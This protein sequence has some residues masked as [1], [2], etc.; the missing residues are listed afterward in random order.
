V[1]RK[2]L[3]AILIALFPAVA[4][5]QGSGNFTAGHALRATG[6]GAQYSD[7]GA[8]TGSAIFGS[9][10]LTELG[11]TN[12]GL[13][14][15]I[16]DALT[17]ATGGYHR[18]CLG[19]NSLGGGLISYDALGGASPLPLQFSVNGTLFPVGSSS[20]GGLPALWAAANTAVTQGPGVVVQGLNFTR[21]S[22]VTQPIYITDFNRLILGNPFTS[23]PWLTAPCTQSGSLCDNTAPILLTHGDLCCGDLYSFGAETAE[24]IQG[25]QI[26]TRMAGAQPGGPTSINGGDISPHTDDIGSAT[27]EVYND[28]T[29]SSGPGPLRLGGMTVVAGGSG[30][31]AGSTF[32]VETGVNCSVKPTGVVYTIGAAGTAVGIT[33]NQGR[34]G[35]CA[36]PAVGTLTTTMLTGGGSGL[37]VTGTFGAP[38]YIGSQGKIK[39]IPYCSAP[40]CHQVVE[41]IGR[42]APSTLGVIT[43]INELVA[44]FTQ[45][46][47]TTG[48]NTLDVANSATLDYASGFAR[49]LSDGPDNTTNGLFQLVSQRANGSNPLVV[50]ST[51]LTGNVALNSGNLSFPT[52]NGGL[53]A[54]LNGT[55]YK[56]NV[57]SIQ[58]KSVDNTGRCGNSAINFLDSAGN[59]HAAF[60]MTNTNSAGC[61]VSGFSLNYAFIELSDLNSTGNKMDFALQNTNVPA[62]PFTAYRYDGTNNVHLYNSSAG[63]EKTKIDG[64][65]GTVTAQGQVNAIG[66]FYLNSVLLVSAGPPVIASGGCTTG[67]AQS[68]S[69]SN[70]SAA[71]EITLGGATCGSTITLTMPAAPHNWVCDAHNITTPASNV[72]DMTG[73]A[74]TT[75]VV[76]TNYVRTTGVAGNFTGADKLAVKCLPY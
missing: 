41:I 50:L 76:L 29:A 63:V 10:Y 1:L 13:P 25:Q 58:N 61:T 21:N 6:N 60:G 28:S 75:A 59:E 44:K 46:L 36:T 69:Q 20:G 2:T 35:I 34:G 17:N 7:G 68:I 45:P 19:A 43:T 71:F 70:G 8:A 3:L 27:I 65:N 9:G 30:Y 38:P 47:Q 74:S 54:P 12:T 39:L 40:G 49:L 72:L 14:L 53:L 57:T 4:L 16:N 66:G 5:A 48:A 15:C 62:S 51:D 23:L 55:V 67:S 33:L 11:I 73:V 26:G 56:D 52:T 32:T 22:S 64:Q 31:A 37:T 24:G 18:L 42:I